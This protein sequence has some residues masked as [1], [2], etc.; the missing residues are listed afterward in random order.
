M[1]PSIILEIPLILLRP[2]RTAV[3]RHRHPL[4]IQAKLLGCRAQAIELLHGPAGLGNAIADPAEDR[5][6][7]GHENQGQSH[8]DENLDERVTAPPLADDREEDQNWA[9]NA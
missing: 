8:G 3:Q 5:Y 6:H 4:Q 9:A 7:G 1:P 2:H